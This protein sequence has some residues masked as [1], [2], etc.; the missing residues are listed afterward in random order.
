MEESE[1]V[2]KLSIKKTMTNLPAKLQTSSLASRV[3][4]LADLVEIVQADFKENE[5]GV[6]LEAVVKAICKVLPHS[7]L[8]R[9]K[10][11]VSRRSALKLVEVR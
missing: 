5:N 6:P 11:S 9:Y 1:G 2:G 7:V 4:L 3:Q 8:P 10:D